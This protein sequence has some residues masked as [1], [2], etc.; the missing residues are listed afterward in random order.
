MTRARMPSRHTYTSDER[1]R[2]WR[3]IREGAIIIG[4]T[5]VMGGLLMAVYRFLVVHYS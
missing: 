4:G 3:E 1:K 5:L 2:Q